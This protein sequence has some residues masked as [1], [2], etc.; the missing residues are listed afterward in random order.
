MKPKKITI[1]MIIFDKVALGFYP[2]LNGK[3]AG[4]KSVLR[5]G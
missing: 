3:I 5:G 1:G 4:I 2:I